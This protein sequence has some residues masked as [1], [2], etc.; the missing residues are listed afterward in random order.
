MSHAPSRKAQGSLIQLKTHLYADLDGDRASVF[1]GRIK[2]PL[3][4]C[5]NGLLVEAHANSALNTN[6]VWFPIRADDH[7][8]NTGAFNFCPSSLIRILRIG[9]GDGTRRCHSPSN[10]KHASANSATMALANSWPCALSNAT[11]R[12]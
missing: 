12:S 5:F 1:G 8:E 6:V 2:S 10:A 9:R 3:L 11:T 7:R 4:N